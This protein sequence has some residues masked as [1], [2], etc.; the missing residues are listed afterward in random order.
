MACRPGERDELIGPATV[1]ADAVQR[2]DVAE[3]GRS[4]DLNRA[5]S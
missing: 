2:A 4:T 5:G 3:A 1:E